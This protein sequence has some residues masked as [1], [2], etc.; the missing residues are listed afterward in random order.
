[1]QFFYNLLQS[2]N[3]YEEF[4]EMINISFTEKEQEMIQERWRILS[5]LDKGLSQRKVAEAVNCSIVTVTRGAKV[6]RQESEKI[7]SFLS[8]INQED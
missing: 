3:S 8:V 5:N 6:Y 4:M 1:M 7:K 2:A